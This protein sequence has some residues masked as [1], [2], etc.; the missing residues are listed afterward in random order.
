MLQPTTI[1]LILCTPGVCTI[2]YYTNPPNKSS[3]MNPDNCQNICISDIFENGTK[4]IP[5]AQSIGYR[6]NFKVSVSPKNLI[7]STF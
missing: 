7:P 3:L 4:L 2:T 6:V 1:A 5:S